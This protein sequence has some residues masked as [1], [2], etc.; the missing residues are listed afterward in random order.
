MTTP[1]LKIYY[2]KKATFLAPEQIEAIR[3]L[4][5]KVPIYTVIRDFHINENRVRDIW[6]NCERL[7][8]DGTTT[9]IIFSQT[10]QNTYHPIPQKEQNLDTL[11]STDVVISHNIDTSS[12]PPNILPKK[13]SRKK[14]F[15]IDNT[16]K[17]EAD[18]EKLM[19]DTNRLAPINPSLSQ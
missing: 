1:Y 13:I 18:L 3:K 10:L 2:R 14:K 17:I 15:S 19:K 16:S 4:K 9:P 5:D 6:N 12:V 11:S 7:Q 8:Q